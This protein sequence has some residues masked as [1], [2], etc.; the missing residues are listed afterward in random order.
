MSPCRYCVA[1]KRYAGCKSACAEY[2]EWLP[3]ELE[4][5]ETIKRNKAKRIGHRKNYL[6]YKPPMR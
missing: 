6:K 4:R 3:G 2:L 5:K 1:P